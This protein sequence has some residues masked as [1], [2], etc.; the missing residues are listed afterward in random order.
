MEECIFS[1]PIKTLITTTNSLSKQIAIK[2]KHTASYL[3]LPG[4]DSIGYPP[5]SIFANDHHFLAKK[6]K[7]QQDLVAICKTWQS[8][9]KPSLINSLQRLENFAASYI[10]KADLLRYLIYNKNMASLAIV[11]DLSF[12]LEDIK[13]SFNKNKDIT[14]NFYR[15]LHN[16]CQE[17][18]CSIL[19]NLSKIISI[20]LADIE[21]EANELIYNQFQIDA[22]E[23]K[24]MEVTVSLTGLGITLTI[25][26]ASGNVFVV[27][28]AIISIAALTVTEIVLNRRLSDYK[29]KNNFLLNK[30]KN[31]KIVLAYLANLKQHFTTVAEALK[32]TIYFLNEFKT[33]SL[34][35]ISN[36]N[37]LSEKIRTV[38]TKIENSNYNFIS[39][40]L[41]NMQHEFTELKNNLQKTKALY[42]LPIHKI[43]DRNG[44]IKQL[45][46]N[47]SSTLLIPNELYFKYKVNEKQH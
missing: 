31:K 27:V 16:C 22:L 6:L 25:G 24:I 44:K 17:L 13:H 43:K 46:S 47:K 19:P 45:V 10:A 39:A 9:Y 21:K 36:F 1:Q 42:N 3:S 5:I 34:H 29:Q 30:I 40:A 37:I 32:K 18:E 35:M 20:K 12:Q 28:A 4:T 38:G 26:A 2:D 33:V 8:S 11:N 14:K 23:K 41:V 7:F 15:Q